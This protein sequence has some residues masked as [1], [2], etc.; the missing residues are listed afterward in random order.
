MTTKA[1]VRLVPLQNGVLDALAEI[2]ME[3]EIDGM[4]GK[5]KFIRENVV[6]KCVIRIC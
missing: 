4:I 1:H 6:T 5:S 2:Q 3:S